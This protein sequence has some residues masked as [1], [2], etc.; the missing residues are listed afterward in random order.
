MINKLFG[1]TTLNYNLLQIGGIPLYF[2][3]VFSRRLHLTY[4]KLC[5]L[6]IIFLLLMFSDD[7]AQAA[8]LFINV[9]IAICIRIY[10][11]DIHILWKLL[12]LSCAVAY[13]DKFILASV[14][15]SYLYVDGNGTHSGILGLLELYRFGAFFS[16]PSRLAIITAML[17]FLTHYFGVFSNFYFLLAIPIIISTV[18]ISGFIL[19][20]IVSFIIFLEKGSVRS[21]LKI[22]AIRIMIG[23]IVLAAIYVCYSILKSKYDSI[24]FLL[25]NEPRFVK[26]QRALSPIINGELFLLPGF[27]NYVSL[28]EVNTGNWA[29]VLIHDY[30]LIGIGIL[31]ILLIWLLRK[32]GFSGM[33]FVLC[34]Y[35]LQSENHF[36]FTAPLI[37][38]LL[39]KKKNIS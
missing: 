20:I 36:I 11:S 7:Y 8:F 37:W 10:P 3:F 26:I 17:I 27:F 24:S 30:R 5:V 15:S 4:K 9:S 16:E 38:I 29:L 31:V 23:L 39:N 25:E 32:V 28:Y 33:L 6:G 21:K 13:F 18:S 34:F 1:A 22:F 14:I 2:L 35:S 19:F 12:V